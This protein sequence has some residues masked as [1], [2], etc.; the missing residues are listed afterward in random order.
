MDAHDI[1][2]M[3][4]LTLLLGRESATRLQ[5]PAPSAEAFD[6]IFKAALRAPDHGRLRP[7]RFVV[8]Q[9]AARERFGDVLAASLRAHRPD[10]TPE[11]LDRERKKPMRAP[12]IVVVAAHV[13]RNGK[14]PEV[15][16]LLSAG[17][18]AQNIMLAAHAQGYGAMWKTGEP[19]YDA[20]VKRALGLE[21]DD[22]IVAFLYLGTR[23]PGSA[24]GA[25]PV[26][27]DFVTKWD[28][29]PPR[30]LV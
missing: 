13:Q 28:G 19:A 22:A 9:G 7:W 17:A 11:M 21:D 14:I 26:P 24:P 2:G 10:A 6:V 8:I 23:A 20:E 18:A 27:Q 1:R 16:Q 29:E 5:E 12:A 30:C 3:D 4:A 15:E 25:R